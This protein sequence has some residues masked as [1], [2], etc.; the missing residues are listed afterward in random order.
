[1]IDA[2][3]AS[4]AIIRLAAF[5]G[6]LLALALAERLAP[7]RQPSVGRV[8]R[9]PSNLGIV[10]LDTLIL[11]LLFPTAAVGVALA[12]DANGWGL[13]HGLSPWLTV[14]V[15]VL[16][17]DLA[18]YGQHVLFHLV[19]PLWRLHRMHHA[20]PDLDV[21]TGLRFHPLE[22]VL[23][24]LIKFAVVLVLGAPALAVLI[25]EVLLN[26]T[27]MFNH[28]NLRL[29]LALDRRLRLFMVTPDMHRVHHSVVPAETNSNYG[30]NLPWWDRLF[31]TYRA[32]PAAGHLGM[33]IGL[34]Q[35]RDPRELRLDRMLLQP[36]RRTITS[37]TI[38]ADRTGPT[39]RPAP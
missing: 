26:A 30:F 38:P 19:P 23:S 5:G 21:T 12:A 16:L 22:I 39:T 4:E 20:D 33:T 27:S 32:Q 25:F 31:G 2:I 15:A 28:A 29:P 11:R 3:F 17:L 6:V 13:L 24:M 8:R 18:I 7:R 37:P 36:L 14:P 1:M 9:W 34:S 35:F 10:V